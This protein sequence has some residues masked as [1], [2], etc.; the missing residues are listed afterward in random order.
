MTAHVARHD[1]FHE[2][3]FKSWSLFLGS[4]VII[5]IVAFAFSLFTLLFLFP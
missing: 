1:Y 5:T 4:I 2:H 3:P